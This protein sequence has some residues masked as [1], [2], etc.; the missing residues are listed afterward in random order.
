MIGRTDQPVSHASKRQPIG[1]R[2]ATT[3]RASLV[4]L[5]RLLGSVDGI[6]RRSADRFG[7]EGAQGLRLLKGKVQSARSFCKTVRSSDNSRFEKWEKVWRQR[8]SEQSRLQKGRQHW[9][10]PFCLWPAR[11]RLMMMQ[12]RHGIACSMFVADRVTA[13]KRMLQI[14]SEEIQLR[15]DI[16]EHTCCVQAGHMLGPRF[17]KA[18]HNEITHRR[19]LIR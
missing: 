15:T 6:K 2:Q 19:V 8:E 5:C 7:S 18:Q 9:T 3:D 13:S 4:G 17:P 1:R 10:A 11:G 16:G 14:S 12:T